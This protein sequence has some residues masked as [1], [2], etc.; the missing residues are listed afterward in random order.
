M[1]FIINTNIKMVK[2]KVLYDYMMKKI[3][4]QI[5]YLKMLMETI[6]KTTTLTKMKKM[7]LLIMKKILIKK[8]DDVHLNKNKFINKVN[9]SNSEDEELICKK[10]K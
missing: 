2:L 1:N 5:L 8:L 6:S 4:F 9:Y 10:S 3:I 7:I